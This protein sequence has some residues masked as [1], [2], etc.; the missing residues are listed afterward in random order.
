MSPLV[1]CCSVLG[2][3]QVV[4]T[5]LASFDFPWPRWAR[6]QVCFVASVIVV[7][8]SYMCVSCGDFF[9]QEKGG[10]AGK[11]S[12]LAMGLLRVGAERARPGLAS[13]WSR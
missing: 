10:E 4:G 13:V 9:L 8:L 7:G 2:R 6:L 3:G 11:A 5:A 12:R 1:R